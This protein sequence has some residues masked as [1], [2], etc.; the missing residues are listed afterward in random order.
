LQSEDKI[1]VI[2]ASSV[3]ARPVK[4]RKDEPLDLRYESSL[5]EETVEGL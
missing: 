2:S 5:A 4:K 1:G 3:I